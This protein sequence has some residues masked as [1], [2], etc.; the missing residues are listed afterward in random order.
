MKVIYYVVKKELK[1]INGVEK[2]TG[3]KTISTYTLEENKLEMFFD[4]G[5]QNSS[6]SEEEI[7]NYLDDN[8]YGDDEWELIRL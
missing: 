5:L 7:Q 3:Y 8:G 2:T 1:V 6:N 4:L